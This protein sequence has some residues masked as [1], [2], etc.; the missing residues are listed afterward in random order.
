MLV[1]AGE[2]YTPIIFEL[3]QEEYE[4]FQGAIINQCIESEGGHQYVV[5]LF[6]SEKKYVVWGNKEELIVFCTCQKFEMIGILC[7]HAHKVL[8]TMSIKQIPNRYIL[9]RWR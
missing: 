7:S 4:I 5:G 9:K 6:D 8:D 1:Q 2:V 3:F